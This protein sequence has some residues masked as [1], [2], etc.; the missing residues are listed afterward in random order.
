MTQRKSCVFSIKDAE[1]GQVEAVFATFDRVDKHGD[2]YTSSAFED[3]AEVL[4]GSW[5][6]GTAF[7]EPPVGKGVIKVTRKDARLVGGYFLDTIAGR[8][9]F[10]V[11]KNV[12]SRQE[13]SY[14]FEILGTGEVTPE[15]RQ[16]GVQRVLSK[17]LVHEVS[18]VMRG[19]GIDT[20]TV[21]AK[22]SLPDDL[23]LELECIVAEHHA[24]AFGLEDMENRERAKRRSP[25]TADEIRD[26]ECLINLALIQFDA[27]R[28]R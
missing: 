2:W 24:R 28:Y 23:E 18:P 5:G 10:S 6:H 22:G 17:L 14:S 9:Q 12:G 19:A 25:L 4:I 7:G 3:G 27:N 13:W 8:D 1:R 21:A 15:L 26:Q 11:L 16:L 20:R